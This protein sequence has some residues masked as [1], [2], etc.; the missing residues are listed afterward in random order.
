MYHTR[1]NTRAQV[2]AEF[3][4]HL[5]FALL[6]SLQQVRQPGCY[7]ELNPTTGEA[8]FA[9]RTA[10]DCKVR[11]EHVLR[12]LKLEDEAKAQE[13]LEAVLSTHLDRTQVDDGVQRNQTGLY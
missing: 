13:F 11:F 10:S 6:G 12:R 4:P 8:T 3:P 9:G 2:R 1:T 5:Y 7:I